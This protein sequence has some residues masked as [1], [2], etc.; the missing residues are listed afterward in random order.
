MD[1]SS[2]FAGNSN[3]RYSD[4]TFSNPKIFGIRPNVRLDPWLSISAI[5]LNNIY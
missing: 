2:L 5:V 3:R 4:G 1:G